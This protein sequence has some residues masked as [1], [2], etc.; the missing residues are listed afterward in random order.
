MT[1]CTNPDSVTFEL[2]VSIQ[3]G[4]S[5]IDRGECLVQFY[6]QMTTIYCSLK[7]EKFLGKVDQSVTNE[8]EPL[9]GNWNGHSFQLGRKRCLI[10][11]NS[12]TCYC[13]LITAVMKQEIGDIRVFFKERLIRQLNHDFRLGESREVA[14]RKELADIRI[15]RTNNDRNVNGTMNQL[16]AIIP[17]YTPRFGPVENWDEL[18]MSH[19]L[20]ETPS[21]PKSG[22][23]RSPDI[24]SRTRR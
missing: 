20:N 19:L 11:L 17:Y 14:I 12:K 1:M 4:P 5:S 3:D 18:H 6:H 16:V 24:F 2:T 10:F 7:L 22:L 15:C 9:F 21:V 8:A 13:I 23:R